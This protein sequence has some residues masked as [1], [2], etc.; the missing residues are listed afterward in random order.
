MRT[1]QYIKSIKK[2]KKIAIETLQVFVPIAKYI[3]IKEIELEL[4][5]LALKVLNT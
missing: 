4:Q 5:T 1:I 2:Q 3:G